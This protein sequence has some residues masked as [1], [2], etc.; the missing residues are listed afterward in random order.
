MKLWGGRFEKGPADEFMAM[1]SS[2]AKDNRLA[3]YDL[4]GSIAY[5]RALARAGVLSPD[6]SNTLVASLQELLRS[7]E[8]GEIFWTGEDE[9]IHSAVERALFERVGAVALKLHTGRSRNEQVV[10]DMR[11]YVKDA[12]VDVAERIHRLCTSITQVASEHV[13]RPMPGY[14]HL[15]HAQPVL[16]SH[17][18]LAWF[19]M[20]KRDFDRFV[21]CYKKT[22]IC[23]LGSG[24]LA[25][26][27][28]GLDRAAMARDL[29]F[30]RPQ[31]N[32]IDAVSDRDFVLHLLSQAANLAIHLSRFA[33]ELVLWSTTEFGFVTLD[34]AYSTGSS[35]MPQKKNP[36]SMELIRARAG[37][38]IGSWVQV[39]TVLKGLPLAYM[40]DLQEDKE[41]VFDA[42][43]SVAASLTVFAG[44]LETARFNFEA[45]ER[46]ARDEMLLATDLADY[47]V[48]KGVPFREAHEIV[49]RVVRE[50]EARNTTLTALELDVYRSIDARFDRDVFAFLGLER[51]LAYRNSYGGTAPERVEEQIATAREIL[52]RQAEWVKARREE[53]REVRSRLLE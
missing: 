39:A 10:T 11:M 31:D 9:D 3:A 33:E 28:F 7:L 24:A 25:G 18:M 15:Q 13:G 52:A 42:V 4:M 44:A 40:R 48:L 6:E 14:T 19:F 30:S 2:I 37:R 34:D 16:F 51:S 38:V 35:L 41:L 32:S 5:A 27:T 47:L 17:H 1:S 50:A 8:S 12:I 21:S 22:D 46:E 26:N 43:D 20:L 29:G 49:G 53:A 36:D 23:P 45:M